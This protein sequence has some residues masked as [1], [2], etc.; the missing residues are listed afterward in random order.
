MAG[1]YRWVV[2][3]GNATVSGPAQ[4]TVRGI[5][6]ESAGVA[7][8]VPKPNKRRARVWVDKRRVIGRRI[9]VL[10]EVFRARIGLPDADDPV[11]AA[12]IARAAEMVAL[13]EHLRALMLRGEAVS[14]DDVL[15]LTRTADALTRR[16]CLD[17][18][19]AT[20]KKSL[21]LS[22]YLAARGGSTP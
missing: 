7:R 6:A 15:R 3:R 19:N 17:H 21:S 11:T 14:P 12:A 5:P 10:V 20:Q 9:K 4:P 13:S 8:A 16:L 1:A 22:D 18:R 2:K